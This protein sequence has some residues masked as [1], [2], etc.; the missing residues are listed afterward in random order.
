MIYVIDRIEGNIAICE[1]DS[2]K[3]IEVDKSLLPS[4]ATEGVTIE[5]YIN[6]DISLLG[7]IE[8]KNRI[9]AKMK[10]AWR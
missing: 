8:R 3:R 4:G 1:D 5:I 9:A 6:G 2:G 10:S 7:D